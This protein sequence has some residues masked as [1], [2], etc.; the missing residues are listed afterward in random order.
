MNANSSAHCNQKDFYNA[1]LHTDHPPSSIHP[2]RAHT[3]SLQEIFE[4]NG[5]NMQQNGQA[6]PM[7]VLENLMANPQAGAGGP[8][9]LPVQ[10]S[11]NGSQPSQQVL[12][13]HQMRLNQLQQLYQLQTQIFQ[14]QV[15]ASSHL[16]PGNGNPKT[17]CGLPGAQPPITDVISFILSLV[18][19]EL[20]SGQSSFGSLPLTMM[21]DPSRARD[22]QQYLPTPGECHFRPCFD[23]FGLRRQSTWAFWRS[24]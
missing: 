10:G 1:Y 17:T 6:V 22:Q 2:S 20:L 14:Q 24:K 16:T 23:T 5:I 8:S 19:I 15:S 13:E 4:M 18:Q 9:S 12:L 11:S 21:G 7:D 3:P